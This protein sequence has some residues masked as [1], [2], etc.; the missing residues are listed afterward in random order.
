M[1]SSVANNLLASLDGEVVRILP[2]TAHEVPVI[3]LFTNRG[4]TTM[5]GDLRANGM[6][7]PDIVVRLGTR[8][9]ERQ[10]S[11]IGFRIFLRSDDPRAQSSRSIEGFYHLISCKFDPRGGAVTYSQATAK[12]KEELLSVR[13]SPV[14]LSR[15]LVSGNDEEVIRMDFNIKDT[16]SLMMSHHGPG[17]EVPR[18]RIKDI[19]KLL[20]YLAYAE[21]L[22]LF[23]IADSLLIR[24]L[25]TTLEHGC[26]G[27]AVASWKT[28]LPDNV[29]TP[30]PSNFQTQMVAGSTDILNILYNTSGEKILQG[31]SR[32]TCPSLHQ[33]II[34]HYA[35]LVKDEMCRGLPC[36]SLLCVR[37]R[38][39][40][41]TR[42]R[43]RWS[44]YLRE[45]PTRGST[46]SEVRP[47]VLP[48]S[49]T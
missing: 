47:K 33:A 42:R 46:I 10:P 12:D 30:W 13:P 34:I 23:F 39:R 15:D 8:V 11:C 14:T 7:V 38:T 45:D 19:D 21:P 3:L 27:A 41:L 22:S 31:M 5:L 44:R 25:K 29:I 32:Y 24:R 16:N 36:I 37:I 9:T 26:V 35:S 1:G 43:I 28:A 6:S 2:E 49:S 20:P 4:R 48:E 18:G 17:L 40:A